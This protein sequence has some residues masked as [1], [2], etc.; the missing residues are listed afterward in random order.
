MV[1]YP[2]YVDCYSKI[3]ELFQ[4]IKEAAVPSKFHQDFLYTKLG[5]K[6]TTHRQFIPLLKK[7]GFLNEGQIPTKQYKDFRDNSIS[8]GILATQIKKAYKDL[9]EANEYAYELKKPEIKDKLISVLGASKE[10]KTMSKVVSTL[11]E[12]LQLADF[13]QQEEIKE[14]I[15]ETETPSD[16]K[17]STPS[18][19]SQTKL[20]ICY[21][22]N[23][24]LPVTSD[25]EVFNAI[26][27]SLKENL[28]K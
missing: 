10:D 15:T 8:K 9:F 4:K 24:N 26:F 23:L 28:L 19:A 1:N 13:E 25:V 2:P 14:E 5:L 17:P 3:K 16:D 20:G 18:I 22:I 6:S 11:W 21:T 12:L 27:K 7:L